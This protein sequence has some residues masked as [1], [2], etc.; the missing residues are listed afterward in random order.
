MENNEFKEKHG[1]DRWSLRKNTCRCHPETCN[2]ND[3]AIY[4][5]ESKFCTVFDRFK[6]EMIVNKLNTCE[7]LVQL[8]YDF[9]FGKTDENQII[10]Y[11]RQK[12]C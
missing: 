9:A 5:N 12:V 7:D 11:V 4:L 10:E 2:C 1:L 3:W 6:A 8:T